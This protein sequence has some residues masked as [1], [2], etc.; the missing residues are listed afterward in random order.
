MIALDT[1]ILVR[2]IT[3]D[4][5][6]Q[7]TLAE[8]LIQQATDEGEACFVSNVVLCE[9]E[10]VLESCY[11]ATRSDLLTAL[12]EIAAR[13]IFAF[14]DSDALHWA[15]NLY[16]KSKVEF[17]DALIGAKARSQGA[18]TTYTFERVLS[19]HDGFS[20]LR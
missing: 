9:L 13:E 5:P 20:L 14:E 15:I 17:S 8:R 4:D 10:W 2:L 19:H 11:E 16:R 7:A 12:Q 6:Q 3:Q 1:N 18:R